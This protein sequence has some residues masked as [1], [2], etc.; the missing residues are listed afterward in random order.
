MTLWVPSYLFTLRCVLHETDASQDLG[1]APHNLSMVPGEAV[2]TEARGE[3]ERGGGGGGGG[4]GKGGLPLHPGGQLNF[5]QDLK[6][7][8]RMFR[9]HTSLPFSRIGGGGGG[10]GGGGITTGMMYPFIGGGGDIT[11]GM[12]YPFINC[13]IFIQFSD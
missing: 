6:E 8:D 3:K 13:I 10:G 1:V 7:W 4:G 9:T 5:K 11:T 12:M 2:L